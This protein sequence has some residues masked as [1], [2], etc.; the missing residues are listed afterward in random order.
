MKKNL[1]A[2]VVALGLWCSAALATPPTNELAGKVS[3]TI[4]EVCIQPSV[5][6]CQVSELSPANQNPFALNSEGAV[7]VAPLCSCT[8]IGGRAFCLP[9]GCGL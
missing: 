1:F 9:V 2:V 7:K 4:D 3:P 5:S 8:V 6:G